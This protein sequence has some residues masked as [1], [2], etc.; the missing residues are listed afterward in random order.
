[1]RFLKLITHLC[2]YMG[3]AYLWHCGYI[4]DS[5]LCLVHIWCLPFD[6]WRLFILSNKTWEAEV[7]LGCLV[8]I[9]IKFTG[10]IRAECAR[11]TKDTSP[12]RSSWSALEELGSINPSPT[13]VCL[14]DTKSSY[15]LSFFTQS[16]YANPVVVIL[17]RSLLCQTAQNWGKAGRGG[18]EHLC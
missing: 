13:L 12:L 4:R 7:W 6:I 16:F 11:E 2:D 14:C 8:G 1:M 15:L 18:E 3:D 9:Q 17:K 5:A 10:K